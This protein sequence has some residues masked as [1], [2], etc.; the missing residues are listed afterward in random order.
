[1]PL[2]SRGVSVKNIE[3]PVKPKLGVVNET[4]VGSLLLDARFLAAQFTMLT[5]GEVTLKGWSGEEKE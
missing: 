3:Y 5:V 2:T 1:M 4:M